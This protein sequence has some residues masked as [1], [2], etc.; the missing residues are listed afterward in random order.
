MQ[1]KG[2]ALVLRVEC[3]ENANAAQQLEIVKLKTGVKKLK[4]I[5]KGFDMAYLRVLAWAPQLLYYGI[6]FN[7]LSIWRMKVFGYD[8]LKASADANDSR[9]SSSNNE[10]LLQNTWLGSC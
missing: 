7:C 8:V 2:F 6:F 1:R 9:P 10:Q 3:L 5:N 4:K